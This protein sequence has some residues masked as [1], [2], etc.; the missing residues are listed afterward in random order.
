MQEYE[1]L[2]GELVELGINANPV[3]PFVTTIIDPCGQI[4]VTACNAMHISP[5]FSSEALAIHLLAQNF[6][7]KADHALTMITTAE[8]ESGAMTN[9]LWGGCYGLN[10]EKIVYGC[11]RQGLNEIWG[12]G[13]GFSASEVI[14]R[15]DSN[16]TSKPELI[17]PIIE[18]ECL[19]SFE[20]GKQMFDQKVRPVLSS[21]L[22]D[23][24]LAGDWMLELED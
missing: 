7:Y 10:I 3:A 18:A 15:L 17:G 12:C 19:Q 2:M 20:D 22:D 21:Q 13:N 11:A 5:L 1:E 14:A 4:L 24:W 6:H 9:I 16:Q 23:F 8:P